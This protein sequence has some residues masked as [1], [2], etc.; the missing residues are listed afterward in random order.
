MLE[1]KWSSRSWVGGMY[2]VVVT[3]TLLF[4]CGGT[5]DGGPLPP[6][7]PAVVYTGRPPAP[8][9]QLPLHS[10]PE[11]FPAERGRIKEVR[12]DV[13]NGVADLGAEGKFAGL[14]F[15]GRIP[16]PTVRV[17]VGDR[18]RFTITNR[19]DEPIA[20]LTIP[21][22]AQAIALGGVVIDHDDENRAIQPG[23]TLELEVT[24]MAAGIH[25]YRGALPTEAEALAAGMYGALIVDPAAGFATSAEREY[26]LVQGELYAR[27][28]PDGRTIDKTAVKVLD[29]G[30]LTSKRPSHFAYDGRF[31]PAGALRLK[32]EP[33]QRVRLFL[34]NAGPNATARFQIQGLPFASVWPAEVLGAKPTP[35]GPVTLPPGSGAIV[36]VVAKKGRFRFLDQQLGSRGLLGLIDAAGGE[37]EPAAALVLAKP[38]TAAE[39]RERGHDL[40][41]ERCV[42]CHE[43]PAGVMRLA[44]DL[45]GVLQRRNR[46]WLVSWLTDPPKMQAEDPI[47]QELLKQWNNV[48]MPQVML[49]ADQI[50]W[51]LEFLGSPLRGAAPPAKGALTES[52]RR[53]L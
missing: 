6:R 15:G 39:R 5:D 40:F 7:R 50:E 25:L 37:P 46:T 49:S 23:Q 47:A 2:A 34:L 18:V 1:N 43:P 13:T 20:G 30:A 44:P 45:A 33:G 8:V 48:S 36:E 16:G 32:A 27:P 21:G 24:A 19:T 9:V 14:S 28:D 29:R 12:L 42:S 4:G 31:T 35:G 3:S 26:A 10:S 38:R 52:G 11:V 22:G 51:M 41:V 17:R 53:V